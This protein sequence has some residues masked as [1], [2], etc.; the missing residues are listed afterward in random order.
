MAKATGAKIGEHGREKG[1]RRGEGDQ[2]F[3]A[4]R[5]T[6]LEGEIWRHAAEEPLTS[7]LPA[8]SSIAAVAARAVAGDDAA[9]EE[10]GGE[11]G[12]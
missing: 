4:Q 7:K 10:E 6:L 5:R 9:G 2:S 3:I 11:G 1:L 12:E 8:L